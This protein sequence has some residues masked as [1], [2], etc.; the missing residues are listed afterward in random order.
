M[1]KGS[2]VVKS[3][4]SNPPLKDMVIEAIAAQKEKSGSS[5]DAIKKYLSSKYQMD[6]IK[7]AGRLNRLLPNPQRKW[8]RRLR[9]LVAG[10]RRLPSRKL[11][12]AWC[13]Y[14]Y[15]LCEQ[16]VPVLFQVCT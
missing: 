12:G 16:T 4:S 14:L 7:Q 1:G 2:A 3:S 8:L 6:A 15:T 13:L 9:R 5:L 10:Q 11:L